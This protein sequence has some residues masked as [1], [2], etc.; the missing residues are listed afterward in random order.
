MRRFIES[1]RRSFS[2]K[3]S[4]WVV[5]FSALV[6]LATQ[7][8]VTFVA[9]RSVREEAIKGAN[10]ILDNS[11]LR[12]ERIISDVESAADN[13]EWLV[14][15]HLDSPDTLLEYSRITVQGNDFLT[16]CAIS[17]EPYYIKGMK[18]FS[19]YSS[20][21]D[22]VVETQQEGD[23][24]YQ[25]FYLEWYL[26]PKLLN[27][28][29]WTE[30]YSDWD[31]DDDYALPTEMLIS[32]CKPLTGPEGDFIGVISLD[33]SLKWL[34][35]TLSSVKPYPNSYSTLVSRG[36]TYLVHPDSEK[37]FYQTLFTD[38]LVEPDPA[39]EQM[40]RSVIA[41]EEGMEEIELD[42]E[43]CY[44]FYKPIKATG[45][46]MAIVCQ[47]KD[48]FGSF[49]RLRA[50]VLAIIL[51][52]LLLL[53][54]TCLNVI[55]KTLQPLRDL[56]AEAG[57]IAEG[58]FGR[59][60]P[61]VDRVDEIGTLSRSFEH[62]QGSLVSYIDEL[63]RTT[64]N[65]ERIEGE[66]R[67]AHAIQMAMVPSV[68]PAFPERK[69]LDLYA[70]MRPAK[71]VGGDL[72]DYFLLG[73]KL[74]FCIGDVSG[75]GIPASLFMA[76]A[77]NLFRVVGKEEVPPA[78]IARRLNDTLS[79]NNEQLM[80]VTAFI[81]VLDLI[82]GHLDFCNCG[83]NP[84]VMIPASGSP[85][86]LDCIPNTPI[87]ACPGW[88]YQGQEIDDLRG[89]AIFL[90]T[91]GLTEAENLSHE[92]FGDAK[93]LAELRKDASGPA[94]AVVSRMLRAVAGHVGFAEPSDDLT[95][96]CLRLKA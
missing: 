51:M 82:T 77:R 60:L 2:A 92:A 15:R 78:E 6:F 35:Q 47:Q 65:K 4:I 67:I 1:I 3:L 53:F 56:A 94:E 83:H 54:L 27:Q 10:Q 68:F 33:I 88:E 96:L 16:G 39:S 89:S 12:L 61:Q 40:C 26:L 59:S 8:Y 28:P 7:S 41:G 64:A 30:P 19:A 38:Y 36:G 55:R 95:I 44:V 11:R 23:D 81:G 49:N 50:I 86:F 76:T 46:A 48:V 24:D 21:T 25:Y 34:S 85:A 84:P 71:E 79:D 18:Y 5:L 70:S 22:G 20:N 62:M 75:K 17:F 63:T 87:G 69:E 90:Y 74:Y 29:C 57:H 13:L 93:L 91:D 52:G 45:W 43:D 42:G 80:F 9:R 31:Y 14:Y 66:L 58:D 72:Y 32:Y 37:L 73:D